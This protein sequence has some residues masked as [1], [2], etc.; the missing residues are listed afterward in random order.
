MHEKEQPLE[1]IQSFCHPHCLS[2]RMWDA[3][4]AIR[5]ESRK[6]MSCGGQ[7][8]GRTKHLHLKGL[9]GEVFSHFKGMTQ[10]GID[11]VE[12]K[13]T[14]KRPKKVLNADLSNEHM[15]LKQE[16]HLLRATEE[17]AMKRF[18]SALGDLFAVLQQR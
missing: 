11:V 16:A 2:K 13:F 3:Q 17:P 6:A 15:R 4:V 10:D 8:H 14:G 1:S 9:N 12:R 18:K 5:E 7:W